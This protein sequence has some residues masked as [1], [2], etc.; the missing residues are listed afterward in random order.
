MTITR[1]VL[2]A[3]DGSERGGLYTDRVEAITVAVLIGYSVLQREFD[4]VR[5]EVIW[6]P[7]EVQL[8]PVEARPR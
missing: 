4:V 1:Y 3:P 8:R 5:D 7:D 2:V 6:T